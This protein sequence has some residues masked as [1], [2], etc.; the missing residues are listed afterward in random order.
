MWDKAITFIL[1]HLTNF[2]SDTCSWLNPGTIFAFKKIL[3]YLQNIFQ[4][5]LFLFPGKCG[6]VMFSIK[7]TDKSDISH[8]VRVNHINTI[9][10]FVCAYSISNL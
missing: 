3:F 10:L 2:V 1:N 9:N 8:S 7:Q 4:Q 6:S 5:S